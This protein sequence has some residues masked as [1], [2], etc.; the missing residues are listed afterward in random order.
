MSIWFF[1]CCD[2]NSWFFM[3][4]GALVS[5]PRAF[6]VFVLV[7]WRC[8]AACI[9]FN[10]WVVCCSKLSSGC[11]VLSFYLLVL[12]NV[13]LCCVTFIVARDIIDA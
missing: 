13:S 3:L 2:L 6:Y 9:W 7:V 10:F 5:P 4:F 12:L 11:W 8:A 1:T